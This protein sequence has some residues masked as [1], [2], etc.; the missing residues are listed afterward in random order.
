MTKYFCTI[1]TPAYNRGNLLPRLYDSIVG[2]TFRDFEWIVVDDG[3]TDNTE[4]VMHQFIRENK[5]PI[6]YIKVENGGKHRAINRG[7]AE[8]QGEVFAIV[9]S[10]DM[11]VPCA[12]EYINLWFS[13]IESNTDKK[14]CGVAACK[15]YNEKEVIGQTFEGEWIDATNIERKKYNILGDKFEIYYTDVMKQYPFPVYEGERFMSEIVVW[16]RMAKDGFYIRWHQDILYLC[17]YL[18]GGLTANNYKLLAN[19]P[20]GYALR[21]REQVQY[22]KLSLKEKL[23][24]YSN[25]F[26]LRRKKESFRE[27]CEHTNA[28]W[29]EMSLAVVLRVCLMIWRRNFNEYKE[30]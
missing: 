3:S 27:M 26:F 20:K 17:N 11:L 30:V 4:E 29:L 12:I 8:S 5:I 10:D 25:Y 28:C 2:Q 21:I 16:T 23:G 22:A 13:E 24:Y 15:G 7:V 9:D 6:R 18:E 19:N 14:F 1:F